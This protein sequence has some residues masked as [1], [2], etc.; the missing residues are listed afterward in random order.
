[1]STKRAPVRTA[2]RPGPS[3]GDQ[4]LI[5]MQARLSDLERQLS[6]RIE[7]SDRV[8][9]DLAR[10][11]DELAQQRIDL[12]RLTTALETATTQVG[13]AEGREITL[14]AEVRRRS[15]ELV[16]L[17]KTFAASGDRGARAELE[18]A[19]ERARAAS[20]GKELTTLKATLE[21]AQAAATA[22]KADLDK[23]KAKKPETK[24]PAATPVETP[25]AEPAAAP[26]AASAARRSSVRKSLSWRRLMQR[27]Q[28]PEPAPKPPAAPKHEAAVFSMIK[29][30]GFFDPDWYLDK[31]P[32]IRQAG[33]DPLEHF[34]RHGASECRRPGPDFD[35]R[36]YI[37]QEPSI[38]PKV[39]NPVIHYLLVGKA[40][41][42][43][44]VRP[45][46]APKPESLSPETVEELDT[47]MASGFFDAAFYAA[48]VPDA[49]KD[50]RAAALHYL[51]RGGV[52]G[53]NPSLRFDSA[54]YTTLHRD[55]KEAGVNPLLHY[56]RH[57]REEGRQIVQAKVSPATVGGSRLPAGPMQTGET[58]ARPPA[59][60]T[61][62]AAVDFP[63]WDVWSRVEIE[64]VKLGQAVPDASVRDVVETFRRLVGLPSDGSP[65]RRLFQDLATIAPLGI[66]DLWFLND[67]DLRVR[68]L[69]DV[70][71]GSGGMV[72]RF[73]QSDS[74]TR[75]IALLGEQAVIAGGFAVVD[76]A[77]S[78]AY[79]PILGTIT[80]GE[81]D[82]LHA[83]IIPFP[84]LIRGGAHHGELALRGSG[85]ALLADVWRA[86]AELADELLGGEGAAPLAV[87]KL[88]ID[89]EGA[90]G[91]ERIFSEDCL[92]WL[93]DHMGLK[94]EVAGK[95][96]GLAASSYLASGFRGRRP[97]TAKRR[98][99]GLTLTLASD[100]LPSLSA[101]VSRRLAP[102]GR[103]TTTGPFVICDAIRARPLWAVCIP[104]PGAN[105]LDLQPSQVALRLPILSGGRREALGSQPSPA[106]TSIPLAIRFQESER[107]DDATLLLPVAVDYAG[108]LLKRELSRAARKSLSLTAIVPVGSESAEALL[109]LESLARQSL[110]SQLDVVLVI[111]PNDRQA[112]VAVAA[113]RLFPRKLSVSSE[114]GSKAARLNKAAAKARGRYLVVIEP[115]VV[116]HDP[117]ALETMAI[118]A[119]TDGVGSVGCVTIQDGGIQEGDRLWFHGGG[120]F[121]S[122]VSFQTNPR[123]IFNEPR[124]LG[125]LPLTTYQVVCNRM[126]L[127][128]IP[129]TVWAA[130]GGLDSRRFPDHDYDLD[131][132]LRGLKAGFNHLCTSIVTATVLDQ[133][134]GD[135]IDPPL[136]DSLTPA[137]W[138]T[139]LARTT[140]L[141]DLR[142]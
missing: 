135:V 73:Y 6:Q 44:I 9:E 92:D 140:V 58:V 101:M 106:T 67:H 93:I 68:V 117:R 112:D 31:Y 83:A 66:A 64:P 74:E 82:L 123:L 69:G 2:A 20:L 120:V 124:S 57:G 51:G 129:S 108:P 37:S 1:M 52:E 12:A 4:V 77:L 22:L 115:G 18:L 46:G 110:R 59:E 36:W 23:A 137:D 79:R 141:R 125:P 105:L 136:H 99:A 60:F 96:T 90:I 72:L 84:S 119:Q 56:L 95:S 11:R 49:F 38:D 100:C 116:A 118:M 55:V 43:V 86:G 138:G 81:G 40:A 102:A 94:P 17:G 91:G 126:R 104:E 107:T 5:A 134:T 21:K 10:A 13:H 88:A 103:G 70:S 29:G 24:Q 54:A 132:A 128:V 75:S 62:T 14:K 7:K 111:D 109:T 41:G 63:D 26:I 127:T 15:E 78:N 8:S 76:V 45:R 19:G 47:I 113:R 87:S 42:R 133:P 25:R 50:D 122:N 27:S 131:F 39:D 65:G 35:V 98:E 121:A 114:P 16:A 32:D 142:Q 130:L 61:W 34:V 33:V 80:N 139:I 48:Q 30:S 53:L 28:R 85:Q 71:D 97:R 89:V 3:D